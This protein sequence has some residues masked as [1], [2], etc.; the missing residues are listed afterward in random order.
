MSFGSASRKQSTQKG[1]NYKHESINWPV[2]RNTFVLF[3]CLLDL[4]AVIF[5][6][7]FVL[8]VCCTHV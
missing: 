7:L 2:S 8:F 5:G 1:N 3:V 6:R 4:L